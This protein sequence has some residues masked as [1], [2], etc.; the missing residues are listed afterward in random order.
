MDHELY[1]SVKDEFTGQSLP[2]ENIVLNEFTWDDGWNEKSLHR[3]KH[4]N[5][6]YPVGDT[7]G[8]GDPW[9]EKG[10][11]RRRALSGYI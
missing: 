5:S 10:S 8:K 1:P 11:Y 3:L 7:L 2:V 6:W 9:L 4:L